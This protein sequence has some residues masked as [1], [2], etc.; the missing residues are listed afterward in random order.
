MLVEDEEEAEFITT[1]PASI[2]VSVSP[3]LLIRKN[4]NDDNTQTNFSIRYFTAA[5]P[6]NTPF[7]YIFLYYFKNISHSLIFN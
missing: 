5:A 3:R 4:E 2:N 7:M 1:H 6:P